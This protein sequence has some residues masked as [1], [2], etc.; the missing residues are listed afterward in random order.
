M[1]G[2]RTRWHVV[3]RAGNLD[4]LA[5]GSRKALLSSGLATVIDL[6]DRS[7]VRR[8]PD[9]FVRCGEVAYLN[10]PIVRVDSDVWRAE[11]A[12]GTS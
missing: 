12:G 1:D 5:P 2:S 8:Y 10:L 3:L 7:E 6:R 9:G 4:R 11:L